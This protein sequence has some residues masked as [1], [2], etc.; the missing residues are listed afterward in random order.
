[1]RSGKGSVTLL[2][3]G[4]G[5]LLKRFGVQIEGEVG[6]MR[7]FL[8]VAVANLES[9]KLVLDAHLAYIDAGSTVI[10]TNSYS[11]VPRCLDFANV[12]DDLPVQGDIM[13]NLIERAGQIAQEA[14]RLR[15][16]KNVKVAGCLPPLNES[17]R[18]D[19]VG[20]FKENVEM[21]RKIAKAV[22]PYSDVLLCET[23]STA[24]EA[25]AACT[26]ALETGLPVWVAWTLHDTEVG[27]LRSGETIQQAVEALKS[28][29]GVYPQALQAC[30]FNCAS[31]EA[32]T[33]AM[34]ELA[35]LVP[36]HMEIGGYAN[37]FVQGSCGCGDY[38]ALSRSEYYEQFVAKWVADGATL[39]GGCCGIF[40]EHIAHISE[41]LNEH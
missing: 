7:R 8:G 40:P 38:R 22:A 17:Y 27:L 21:Y 14:C 11:C 16:N 34:A 5:H 36:E 19:M 32:M 37:G 25:L 26:A 31:P 35:A 13:T 29:G 28:P 39:V 9:P 33:A 2:D 12:S 15:P 20:E 30:L 24:Q 3:G 23:M 1:M 41:R 6:T 10:T 4:M 18:P